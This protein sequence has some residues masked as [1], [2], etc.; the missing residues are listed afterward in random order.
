VLVS[1]KNEDEVNE[2][3]FRYSLALGYIMND[4][5]EVNDKLASKCPLWDLVSLR[6]ELGD[7][8]SVSKPDAIFCSDVVE[9]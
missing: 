7:S 1:L 5:C 6:L 9:D 3:L 8:L 2:D 4:G